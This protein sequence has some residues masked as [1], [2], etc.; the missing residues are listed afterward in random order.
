MKKK[1][2]LGAEKLLFENAKTLRSNPTHAEIILWSY[3]KQRPLGYKFR[4]QHPISI[5]IADFYCHSIKLI[6][7]VDGNVHEEIDTA[8]KDAERQK[9]L[10]AEGLSFIRFT[11]EQVEKNMEFVIGEIETYLKSSQPK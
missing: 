8:M 4:R 6:I 11:N 7:E 1:M 9:S 10:E 2:F 3:L 5:Y